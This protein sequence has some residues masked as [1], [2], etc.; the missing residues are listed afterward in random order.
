MYY[1]FIF[2]LQTSTPLPH[3][4]CLIKNLG[5]RHVTHH[6]TNETVVRCWLESPN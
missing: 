5:K 1:L 4:R 2:F 3:I 6:V